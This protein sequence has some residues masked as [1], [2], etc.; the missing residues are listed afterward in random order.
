MP[1][2]AY[3]AINNDAQ[4]VKGDVTADSKDQAIKLIQ[5][6][7]LRPT[8]LQMQKDAPAK[9]AVP[10]VEQAAPKKK[11]PLFKGGVK[12]AE[13]V[14]FTTQ[15]STL[16]DAG[17]PIVRSLNILEE[18]QKP[19]RL[20]D[21]LEAISEEVEQGST[22]SEALSKYPK[23]FNKL[24]ISMVKAGEA[25]GVLDVILRRLAGFMEKSQ[26]LRK[27]VKGALDRKSV[28]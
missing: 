6:K 16:Q 22:F 24:Y 12:T 11:G 3:E 21:E 10:G 25:G 8:R 2:F 18:Q 19:G 14:T 1:V 9:R 17:L 7:G 23:S 26:K 5:E 27:K 4:K 13:I 28:V 15:L 20:K